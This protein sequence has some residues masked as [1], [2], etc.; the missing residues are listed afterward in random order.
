MSTAITV[1]P[2]LKNTWVCDG[3]G[4]TV[5]GKKNKVYNENYALERGV[6]ECDDCKFGHLDEDE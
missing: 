5:T 4:E 3:C 2:K 6:Y 1:R